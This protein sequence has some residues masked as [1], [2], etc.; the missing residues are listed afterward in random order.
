V[1]RTG[2]SSGQMGEAICYGRIGPSLN[3]P[4]IAP[5][6]A[7]AGAFT[8]RPPARGQITFT[9]STSGD[10][11]RCPHQQSEFQR[12][13]P[14]AVRGELA[15]GSTPH[16]ARARLARG[17]RMLARQTTRKTRKTSR[18]ATTAGTAMRHAGLRKEKGTGWPSAQSASSSGFLRWKAKR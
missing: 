11:V 3:M 16:T 8:A 17:P 15:T 13:K 12:C 9:T 7:K 4:R 5:Y 18:E 14:G 6:R 10:S 2:E 1:D